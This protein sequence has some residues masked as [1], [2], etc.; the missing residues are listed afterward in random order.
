MPVLAERHRFL[1]IQSLLVHGTPAFISDVN[2][3]L[4]PGSKPIAPTGMPLTL[5]GDGDQLYETAMI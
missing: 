4:E 2:L 5:P 3:F 1:P